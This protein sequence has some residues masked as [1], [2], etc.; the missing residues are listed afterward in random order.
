[1]HIQIDGRMMDQGFLFESTDLIR[2]VSTFLVDDASTLLKLSCVSKSCHTAIV[3]SSEIWKATC[4]TRW[5]SKWGFRDRW[6]KALRDEEPTGYWWR[7]IY[8]RQEEDASRESITASELRSFTFDFRF[9]LSQFWRQGNLLASGLKWTASQEFP[10][11]AHRTYAVD[12]AFQWPGQERGML[13][14]HP[15][16]RGFR[17][18]FGSRLERNAMG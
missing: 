17:M 7:D 12:P 5:K 9:W 10:F 3:G 2:E 6:R 11:A 16:G 14:G 8:Q 13:Q 1:M 15:S 4:E 18:I